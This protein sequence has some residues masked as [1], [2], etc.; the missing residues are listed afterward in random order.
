METLQTYLEQWN[1]ILSNDRIRQFQKYYDLLVEWNSFMNLTTITEPKDVI[2]KHFVDSLALGHYL[3]LKAQTVLDLGT[4]AGFPGIPLKIAFPS[5]RITLADSQQK[6]IRFLN[7][8]L[9]ELSFDDVI[10]LHGRAE[11]LAKMKEYREQ[12]DICT[13]RAVANLTTLSEYCIPFVKTGGYFVSYKSEKTETELVEAQY[14]IRILGGKV[15]RTE[16]FLLPETDL[17]RSLI[18]IAKN[19][20]TPAKY[21][22]KAGTPSKELLSDRRS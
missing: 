16:S 3:D 7:T 1:I 10:T 15:E 18:F 22:R 4:G 20:S 19:R 2:I 6:R 9:H 21:P 17:K 11:D 12:F 13:S 14:A 8:V 5:L